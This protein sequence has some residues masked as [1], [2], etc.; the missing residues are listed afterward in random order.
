MPWRLYTA[1][2]RQQVEALHLQ[3]HERL[4]CSLDLPSLDE[5][6]VLISLVYEDHGMVTHAVFL[7]AE[8]EVCA[9]GKAPLARKEWEEAAKQLIEVC[10]VYDLRLVRAFVPQ[11]AMNRKL[12]RRRSPIERI[13]RFFGFDQETP[14]ELT[15]FV[16]W[17]S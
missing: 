15:Q 4:G 5:R 11:A 6:P 9:V 17:I 10:K 3:M 1:A 13:L 7:E 12:G 16:R 8:A 14:D 2:D